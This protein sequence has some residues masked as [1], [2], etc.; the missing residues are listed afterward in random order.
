M[1]RRLACLLTA[2][3]LLV[4]ALMSPFSA[5]AS[6]P[7]PED[8]SIY[9]RSALVAFLGTDTSS[10]MIMF[11]KNAD[12]RLAPAGL[13]RIMVG[14]FA[15]KTLEEQNMDPTVATGTFT[16]AMKDALSDHGVRD[17]YTVNMKEGDVWHVE[18]LLNVAMLQTAAD[19]VT[20]LV[21]TLAGSQDAYVQ[22][23]NNMLTEI[24]CTDTH[25]T[26]VYG[27][28]DP[29]QYTSARDMY[30]ILRY[31]S[32]NY[33]RL[34]DILGNAQYEVKPVK[35]E[36]DFWPT[37]NEMLR[38]NSEF[39]YAP[40]VYGRSGFT[41]SLGQSCASV[42]RDEGYE[43]MTVVLGCDG[44]QDEEGED[45]DG[46][47]FTDTMTLC[48]WVYNAFSYK[49]VISKNQPITRAKVRL[50]WST[51]SVAL[52]AGRDLEGMLRNE[53]DVNSLRYD[54]VLNEEVLSAPLDQG[55]V[56]GTAKVYDGEVL[57]GEVDLCSAEYISRSQLL[58]V[59]SGI[60]KVIS[61]PVMLILLALGAALF[62]GYLVIGFAHSHNRKKKKHKK[63]KR[64]R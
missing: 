48:R 10:D 41:E 4:C 14:L 52:V 38:P 24:G 54:I 9:A 43:Y 35:G 42:C 37:T 7:L 17:L 22:G 16:P 64:Y 18:D 20:T 61:S 1:K 40:I 46:E 6:Y 44:G 5:S 45:V 53:T 50:A 8:R 11:E 58:F 62:I 39:Y 59:L 15:L 19:A 23:M 2:C 33:A 31:A 57:V 28:D 27:L 56:C 36:E 51:D 60:W 26:N 29:E 25:F 34:T 21:I 12:E 49:T 13:T 30:R 3:L 47:A 32:I 55:E 63:V